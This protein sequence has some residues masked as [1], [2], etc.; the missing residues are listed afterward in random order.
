MYEDNE[1]HFWFGIIGFISWDTSKR[2]ANENEVLKEIDKIMIE[3]ISSNLVI[4]DNLSSR[5]NSLSE[6]YPNSEA[7]HYLGLLEFK[8]LFNIDTIAAEM[9]QERINLIKNNIENK[10]FKA[11]AFL[12]SGDSYSDNSDYQSAKEDY[13]EAIKYAS[14]NAQ[15]GYSYYKLGNIYFEMNDLSK[16]IDSFNEADN[17]FNSSKESASLARDPQFQSWVSRNKIALHRTENL[18]KK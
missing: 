14:S 8:N 4:D 7:V 18:L 11:Q 12:I 10:W 9:K 17:L 15:K 6:K 1:I 3:L 2:Q 5:I 13:N 16:A